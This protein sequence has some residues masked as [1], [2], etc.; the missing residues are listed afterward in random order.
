MI[1]PQTKMMCIRKLSPPPEQDGLLLQL[2]RPRQ[3]LLLATQQR[4][5]V[6]RHVAVVVAG[7]VHAVLGLQRVLQG[8]ERGVDLA[9]LA[10]Q[11]AKEHHVGPDARFSG[12]KDL[13]RYSDRLL[14]VADGLVKLARL[15]VRDG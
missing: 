6:P 11:P 9:V 2:N 10:E 3:P 13:L 5:I 1:R 14:L 7:P 8:V 15:P 4:N 12:I